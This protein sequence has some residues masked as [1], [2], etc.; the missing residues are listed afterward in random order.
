M[1]LASESSPSISHTRREIAQQPDI[2]EQAIAAVDARRAE[3]DAWLAP[4]RAKPDL[5]IILTG[6]GSSAYIGETLAPALAAHLNRPVEAISTTSLVGA[7]EGLLLANRPT[8]LISYGRSGGSPESLAIIRAVVAMADSLEMSTTAEG[9]E[10]ERELDVVR[11]LGC[12]K[13]QGYYFGRPMPAEDALALFRHPQH[14]SRG[15]SAA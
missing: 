13:V 4:L 3:L 1:N 6:A 12:G 14:L 10:T 7:P 8:L 11:A 9:V 15:G 5:R 2:W